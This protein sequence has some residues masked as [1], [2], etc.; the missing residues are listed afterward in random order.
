M[1]ITGDIQQRYIVTHC[2]NTRRV[3]TFVR[4]GISVPGLVGTFFFVFSLYFSYTL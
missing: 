1:P 4:T 2:N 3:T